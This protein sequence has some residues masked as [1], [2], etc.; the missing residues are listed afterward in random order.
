MGQIRKEYPVRIDNEPQE[1]RSSKA[2]VTVW[3]F[4]Y[5]VQEKGSWVAK[6]DSL[7]ASTLIDRLS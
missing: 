2:P 5:R 1:W 7:D 6:G 4:F 3:D